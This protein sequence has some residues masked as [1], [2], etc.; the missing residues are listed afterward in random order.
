M[1]SDNFKRRDLLQLLAG[2]GLVAATPSLVRAAPSASPSAAPPYPGPFLVTVHAGGGWDPTNLCDPKGKKDAKE[3]KPINNF[4]LSDVQKVGPFS[5]AP[6][7]GAVDFFKLHKDRLIV[8]NGVDTSTNGHDSGTRHVWSGNLVEGYPSLAALFA[9]T[10]AS[11][12]PL[13]F[14]SSGGYDHTNGHIAPTRVGNVSALNR[15]TKPNVKDLNNPDR[16]FHDDWVWKR[17]LEVRAKRM[18]RQ[19][20]EVSLPASV[21]AMEL[22]RDARLGVGVLNKLIEK[23]PK[24]LDKSSNPLKRQ[25]EISAAT[26]AAGL[27]ASASLTLGGFDTHANHD[28][29]HKPRLTM[30]LDGVT[31]LYNQ[32]KAQGIADKTLIV[33]SSDFGRT[34]GYNAGKG[35]DHWSITSAMVLGPTEGSFAIKGG[36]VVGTTTPAHH[37][38]ELDPKTLLPSDK[39]TGVRLTPGTLH[40]AL[41]AH[42]GLSDT[43]LE[44]RYLIKSPKLAL[45]K[46]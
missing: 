42:L 41:R 29:T 35:K 36:R 23:M 2:A 18:K 19:V 4:L 34:P 20:E 39:K 7:P 8:F 32:L 16:R 28:A 11:K 30:L 46:G 40:L 44:K 13:A 26:F 3:D 15:L 21:V 31:Y 5:V 27:G 14:L 37:P 22:L 38:I 24:T 45:L 10:V 9:A 6:T 25:A 12:Q 43:E 17:L 33:V 1:S